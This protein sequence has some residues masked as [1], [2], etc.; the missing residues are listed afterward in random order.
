MHVVEELATNAARATGVMDERVR[1]T[2]LTRS[3]FI[4][5]TVLAVYEARAQV[6]VREWTATATRGE[7]RV[8]PFPS[9]V[10]ENLLAGQMTHHHAAVD[11]LPPS[12]VV[13]SSD[14]PDHGGGDFGGGD[15]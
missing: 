9:L 8:Q 5:S 1:W 3:E 12:K 2:E 10:V 6:D 15:F 11:D 13:C 14:S 4:G 7:Q